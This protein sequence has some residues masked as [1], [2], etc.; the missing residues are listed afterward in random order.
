MAFKFFPLPSAPSEYSKS[1]ES[2]FRRA[3]ENSLLGVYSEI[4]GSVSAQEG[5][6]SLASKRETLLGVAP[7]VVFSSSGTVGPFTFAL[8]TPRVDGLGRL[9]LALPAGSLTI[10]DFP[11]GVSGQRVT[12]F[13]VSSGVVTIQ[14]TSNGSS[15]YLSGGNDLVFGASASDRYSNL[16]IEKSV[17]GNWV[18]VARM[19]R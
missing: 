2:I 18:E 3:V 10:T 14:D 17:D 12:V 9:V 13:N 5:F 15:I 16:T 1:S 4:E 6:A 7:G 11:G 19:I 8:A